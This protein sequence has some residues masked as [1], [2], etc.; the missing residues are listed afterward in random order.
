MHPEAKLVLLEAESSVG[1][2]WGTDR[3]YPTLKSNNLVGTYESPDF[4]MDEATWGVAP[5]THI[6][7]QVMHDYLTAFARAFSVLE[8]TRFDSRVLSIERGEK[9]A[10]W[11]L[12]VGS[13]GGGE[14]KLLARKLVLA[15]G[16][17]SQPFVPKFKGS[18]EFGRPLFHSVEFWQHRETLQTLERVTVLGGT[19]SA[20]DAVYAYATKGVH[21]DWVIRG[22]FVLL[23]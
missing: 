4:P 10:G 5:G 23:A 19:K 22:M 18:E 6:S 9:G 13:K 15:T 12:T 16:M 2:V 11:C 17:T 8:R 14:S 20:W 21:V 1:G 7:A 3:L